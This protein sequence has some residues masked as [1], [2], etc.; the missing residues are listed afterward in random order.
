MQGL[1]KIKYK[2]VIKGWFFDHYDEKNAWEIIKKNENIKISMTESK[3]KAPISIQVPKKVNE[4]VQNELL[5]KKTQSYKKNTQFIYKS[6]FNEIERENSYTTSNFFSNEPKSDNI[7]SHLINIDKNYNI[8]LLIKKLHPYM[9]EREF[10]T[11]VK[12]P[13]FLEKVALVC[14]NCYLLIIGSAHAQESL[15]QITKK[16]TI[17]NTH[18]LGQGKLNPESLNVRF[19]VFYFYLKFLFIKLILKILKGDSPENSI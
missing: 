19:N 9:K 16:H 11:L 14:E 18:F 10:K 13:G 5:S 17:K 7:F 12:N 3:I 4:T 1:F 15:K 8:P 6:L 2:D